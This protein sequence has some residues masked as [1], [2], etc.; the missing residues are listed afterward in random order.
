MKCSPQTQF[1]ARTV[2]LA[3]N[4]VW[5]LHFIWA[6]FVSVPPLDLILLIINYSI[7]KFTLYLHYI[8][9]DQLSLG[10][11][12]YSIVRKCAVFKFTTILNK[13]TVY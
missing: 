6:R 8:D 3:L 12:N 2:V 4:W 5:G 13:Q 7:I 11:K 9:Y 1:S 10:Q